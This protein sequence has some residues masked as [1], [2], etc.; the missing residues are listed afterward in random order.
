MSWE[1]G[2]ANANH[3]GIN[4]Y[5]NNWR[6]GA[7][8]NYLQGGNVGLLLQKW[9]HVAISRQRRHE[10]ICYSSQIGS[11]SAN[12]DLILLAISLLEDMQEVEYTFQGYMQDWRAYKE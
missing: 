5:N 11:I 9:S 2:D 12:I 6:I 3:N 7:F 8:N 1:G 4:I 10:G